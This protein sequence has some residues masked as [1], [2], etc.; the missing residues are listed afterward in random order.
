M[1]PADRSATRRTDR[2][3]AASEP[4][5]GSS[6]RQRRLGPEDLDTDARCHNGGLDD[7]VAVRSPPC[8]VWAIPAG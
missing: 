5:Q 2:A 8:F 7:L 4:A 6:G 1:T 3:S